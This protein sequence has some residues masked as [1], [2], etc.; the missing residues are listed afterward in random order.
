MSNNSKSNTTNSTIDLLALTEQLKCASINNEVS[1]A[2]KEFENMLN[3]QL[4]YL[5]CF[6][7]LENIKRS[8]ESHKGDEEI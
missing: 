4:L 3:R 5:H 1:D 8:P 2:L 7:I 6:K